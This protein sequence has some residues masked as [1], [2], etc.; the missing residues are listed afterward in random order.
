MQDST[1]FPIAGGP[2]IQ[3]SSKSKW[4][5]P[6][7]DTDGAAAGNYS[8]Q[9]TVDLTGYDPRTAFLAGSWAADDSGSIFLNGVDTGFSGTNYFVSFSTFTLTNGFVSGTNLIEFRVGNGGSWTGL[10]VEN[11]RGAALTGVTATQPTLTVS[12]ADNGIR[13]VWPVSATGFVL[14]E[15]ISP[16]GNWADSSAAVVVQGNENVAQLPASAAAMK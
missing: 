10:R 12:L 14:Q 9:L 1:L 11:L 5:G 15:T 7:L 4:I 13:L 2:W 6:A 16:S 3:N 8:Y